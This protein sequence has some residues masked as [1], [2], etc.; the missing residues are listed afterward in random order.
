MDPRS[1]D[2]EPPVDALEEGAPTF[3][4]VRVQLEWNAATIE[5]WKHCVGTQKSHAAR[6]RAD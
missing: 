4:N 6:Y 5:G 3:T 2:D 1:T